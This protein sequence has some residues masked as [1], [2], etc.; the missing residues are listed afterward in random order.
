M[1]EK[2]P[3]LNSKPPFQKKKSCNWEIILIIL[4]G[5]LLVG[6]V[7][8]VGL[9]PF[10]WS[11]EVDNQS[12]AWTNSLGSQTTPLQTNQ[13]LLNKGSFSVKN[14]LRYAPDVFKVPN[15]KV[16]KEVDWRLAGAV[17]AVKDQGSCGNCYAQAAVGT[18]EGQW[19][20]KTGNLVNLSPDDVSICSIPYGNADCY[21][22]FPKWALD[23][24]KDH[25]V[26][27]SDSYPR[28]SFRRKCNGTNRHIGATISDYGKTPQYDEEALKTAVGLIG[29]VTASIWV[30]PSFYVFNGI[31]GSQIWTVG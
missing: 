24:V 3:L 6:L 5:G 16:P 31:S 19:F 15:I 20:R 25:G 12:V 13:R 9:H 2:S 11:N 30:M 22:G 10:V 4:L 23:F 14:E 1:E 17:T 7:V 18:V 29:P 21:G 26:A 27:T 8:F 28:G